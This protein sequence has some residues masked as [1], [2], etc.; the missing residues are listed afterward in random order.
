MNHGFTMF[1]LFLIAGAVI[2]LII[3]S[4][5]SFSDSKDYAAVSSDL[6]GVT[7]DSDSISEQMGYFNGKWNLWEY[8]GDFVA[9]LFKE[10][11][12]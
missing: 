5:M 9:N 6:S 11:Q 7:V 1:K 4:L 10:K 3:I 12:H 2:C 8:I